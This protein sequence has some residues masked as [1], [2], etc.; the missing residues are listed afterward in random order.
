M[1]Q[2]LKIIISDAVENGKKYVNDLQGLINEY[3]AQVSL[4]VLQ[5]LWT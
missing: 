1:H 2:T 5:I 4:V 3:P